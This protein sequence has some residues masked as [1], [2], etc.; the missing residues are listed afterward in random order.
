MSVIDIGAAEYHADLTGDT[1]TLS[2]STIKTLLYKSPAH[3][4]HAHPKLNAA[5]QRE[6]DDRFNLGTVVH[7]LLL[8]NAASNIEVVDAPDWRTKIA[9]EAKE[10]AKDYGRIPMLKHQW[11]E[12]QAA[13][14]GIRD[15]IAK[16]NVKPAPF[17]DG[18][19][20]QSIVW[21][22]AGV[23]CRALIDWWHTNQH[24]ID[25]LKT[26]ER[27]ANPEGWTRRTLFEIGADIQAAF[28]QRGVRAVAGVM[29]E[30]RF[31]VAETQPPYAVSV[32]ALGPDVLELAN[33]KI[34][35]ALN[36]WRSCLANDRWPSYP[37]DVC[38]AQL[39][40]WEESRWLEREIREE[41]AA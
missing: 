5:Y 34:D 7:S 18:H 4:W 8:E 13:V 2:A 20:E 21:D 37:T 39:P 10:W 14:N 33:R 22:E 36:L 28:Y 6:Q 12:A 9:K 15:N 24:T 17:T 16:L 19:P 35:Y 32:V 40:P 41:N 3:A 25:D 11:D 29:P 30:F 26:T 27:S 23:R 1:P 31:V 38:Y